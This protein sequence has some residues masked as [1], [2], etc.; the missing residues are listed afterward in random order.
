MFALRKIFLVTLLA[1]GCTHGVA[2]CPRLIDSRIQRD[3]LVR[4]V[5]VDEAEREH[6][7]NGVPFGFLDEQWRELKSKMRPG[8]EL[9]LYQRKYP[10]SPPSAIAVGAEIGYVVIRDCKEAGSIVTLVS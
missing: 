9:W 8:D 2:D 4:R 3:W 7:V 10:P 1:I 6:M 5:T